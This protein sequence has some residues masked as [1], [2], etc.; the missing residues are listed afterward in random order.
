MLP[1][2]TLDWLSATKG[3]M[4]TACLLSRSLRTD[5]VWVDH[6]AHKEDHEGNKQPQGSF[7][8]SVP[9]LLQVLAPVYDSKA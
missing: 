5:H 7:R 3:I 1:T 2:G 8:P 6:Q 4:Y 9:D